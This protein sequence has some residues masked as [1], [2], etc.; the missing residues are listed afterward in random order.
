MTDRDNPAARSSEPDDRD[1]DPARDETGHDSSRPPGGASPANDDIPREPSRQ[2]LDEAMSADADR[3]DDAYATDVRGTD[4]ADDDLLAAP[5]A[6]EEDLTGAPVLTKRPPSKP[7]VIAGGILAALLLGLALLATTQSP[8]EFLPEVNKQMVAGVANLL[9]EEDVAEY[10][11]DEVEAAQQA[12]ADAG[13]DRNMNDENVADALNSA[14]PES[15]TAAEIQEAR[16]KHNANYAS[17][18]Q[19]ESQLRSQMI[20]FAVTGALMALATVFYQRGKSWARYIGMFVAGF[21]AVMYVMQVVQGAL[22]IPGLVITV[23]SVAAFYFFMKGR[24]E[25]PP[26]GMTGGGFAG[27]GGMFAPR[28]PRNRPAE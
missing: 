14:K 12:Y 10:T 1:R 22:N 13:G 27:F 4:A 7:A 18:E 11:D 8:R 15:I 20:L 16:D 6:P 17:L 28:G 2:E 19:M 26:P 9:E 21:V 24:L 23:A 5:P 3:P 25:D